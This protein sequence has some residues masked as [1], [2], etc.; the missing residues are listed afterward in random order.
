MLVAAKWREF[1]S[2]SQDVADDDI[3]EEDETPSRRN[4]RSSGR[5]RKQ[6]VVEDYDFD[7][8]EDDDFDKVRMIINI[9]AM[10]R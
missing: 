2:N 1:Q 10:A 7:E 4:G 5:V 6:K 8:E 9:I 3:P